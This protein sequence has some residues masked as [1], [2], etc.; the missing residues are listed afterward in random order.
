MSKTLDR[1]YEI[2][3]VWAQNLGISAYGLIWKK[4]RFSGVFEKSL[5]D[6]KSR[7]NF[8]DN[9]WSRYQN[10]EL[11][12]LISH[13]FES[14]PFYSDVF[15]R[16]GIKKND[17]AH[18]TLDDLLSLPRL[19]KESIRRNPESFID[20][21]CTDT[22]LHTYLSSGSTGTPLAIKLSSATQQRWSAAYETRCRN[23]A[24][25]NFKMSRAMIGGRVVVPKSDSKP[26][27][28]RYNA[29]ERQL[30][31]SAFHI[32]PSN[33]EHYSEALNQYQPDYLVGYASGHY[34]LARMISEQQLKIYQPKAVL[35]S[36]EKLTQEMRNTI[37]HAYRCSVYD[38]Y[39]G[40]EAC[41]LASECE[42]HSLHISPDVGI[43]ELLD[44]HGRRV[45]PGQQG[46]IV[47]TGLLNFDQP[48]I[49]YRTGDIAV[50]SPEQCECGRG[51]P[52]LKEL[53]GRLEDTV[54]GPDGREM[55][56][57]HGI[58]VGLPSIRE[59]QVIQ[60]SH[61][62]FRLRLSVDPDF[63]EQDRKVIGKRF[64]ERLGNIDL[65]I[66]IVDFIERS[67]GGKFKA[68]ISNLQR[69][70]KTDLPIL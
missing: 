67:E 65:R 38:A 69:S 43:I 58:F 29:V 60:E 6:F 39:S 14:V 40:V 33:A 19:D 3:P 59:G 44:E 62:K 25:V 31:M 41:C 22:K 48:L 70:H 47:A 2:S 12:K 5:K 26:P 10:N 57:F 34:F 50:L 68:V 45:S 13:A 35:T 21:H 16:N 32:S 54:I 18:F 36:S 9:E 7:E 61:S 23:L 51:M 1:L 15:R 24:G 28:W 46:E 55:V 63:S 66:E 20:K 8:T 52:I 4:R 37:E 56:R 30:Y 17:L 27:Y 11:R 53:V 49:R 64:K 42:H